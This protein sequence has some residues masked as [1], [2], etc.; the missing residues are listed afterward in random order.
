[1][2]GISTS[3]PYDVQLD[4]VH[5]IPALERAEI[6]RP[7]YAVE[8]D[9]F[10]PTQLFP[11]LETRLLTGLYFAGQVNGTS[12]YEEAAAQGLI[13]G[14]NAALKVQGRS[15]IVLDRNQAYI[16]VLIDDLV[17]KGTE[18]PYRM[19]TS[20]AEDRLF[21]RQDNADQRLTNLAFDAG[22]ISE[23]YWTHFQ[24]KLHVVSQLR[25]VAAE[26]KLRGTPICQLLKRPDFTVEK[27][28]EELR[29]LASAEIWELIETDWKYEGYALR[30]ASQNRAIARQNTQQIPDGM[31]YGKIVG[32]RCET[33]QR[34]GTIRPT[35]LGQAARISGITPADVAIISIWLSKNVLQQETTCVDDGVSLGRANE[36]L[37]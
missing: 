19:F 8:Y 18:E 26:T 35:T 27:L 6:M 7:G 14:A 22:L 24:R 2:N 17:T 36:A 16:G 29:S 10:P 9:F 23:G 33:R 12:G 21:L 32:L 1:M 4:F 25:Q 11:T 20:R 3:L 30:Q 31:D 37:T 15:P 28:P 13:A 34:L 5:S